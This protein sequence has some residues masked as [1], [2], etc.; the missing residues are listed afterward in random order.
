VY[1]V[2]GKV[3]LEVVLAYFEL[4]R[5]LSCGKAEDKREKSVEVINFMVLIA[6]RIL[7]SHFIQHRGPSWLKSVLDF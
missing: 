4:L 1:A 3:R 7:G 5:R 6:P 2:L